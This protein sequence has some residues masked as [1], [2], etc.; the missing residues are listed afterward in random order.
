[1]EGTGLTD[2]VFNDMV[3]PQAVIDI[4]ESFGLGWDITKK[5]SNE[6][7]AL[8]HSGHDLAIR[9]PPTLISRRRRNCCLGL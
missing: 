9:L 6:E 3:R 5:L 1:M 8:M 4:D 2:E 7:Y